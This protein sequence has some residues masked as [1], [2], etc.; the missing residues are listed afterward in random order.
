MTH[1]FKRNFFWQIF[2]LVFFFGNFLHFGCFTW[3]IKFFGKK[4]TKITS[5]TKS[6]KTWDRLQLIHPYQSF[7]RV[8]VSRF[9][10][11]SSWENPRL[12]LSNSPA[13]WCPKK[14]TW[15]LC[16]CKTRTVKKIKNKQQQQRWSEW[17][18]HITKQLI[19]G[20]H[21]SHKSM[22]EETCGRD[23]V[24]ITLLDLERDFI[25]SCKLWQDN[26][27]DV[28]DSNESQSVSV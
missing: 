7:K 20:S 21:Q 8:F 19:A 15:N 26:A 24:T 22:V 13:S 4:I 10:N 11:I 2:W 16:Q 18:V 27:V 23:I 6:P 25:E 28:N 1:V 12:C 14:K 3:E 5:L 17:N 9:L